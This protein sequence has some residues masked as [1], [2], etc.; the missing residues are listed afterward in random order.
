MSPRCSPVP[1]ELGKA[2]LHTIT[3]RIAPSHVNVEGKG[4]L[5]YVQITEV[6]ERAQAGMQE[7]R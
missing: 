3:H 1:Q 7:G 6:L 2:E 5:P 4:N